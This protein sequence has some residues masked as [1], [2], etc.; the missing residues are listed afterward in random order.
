MKTAAL[1]AGA[2]FTMNFANTTRAADAAKTYK[3]QL[4][5]AAIVGEITA[6][7]MEELTKMGYDGVETTVWDI[8]VAIK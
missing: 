2:A 1:G 7:R 4:H 3:T 5:K 8:D 6:E